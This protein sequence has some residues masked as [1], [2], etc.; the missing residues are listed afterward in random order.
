MPRMT[1]PG[2]HLSPTGQRWLRKLTWLIGPLGLCLL[3][4]AG[5][6]IDIATW[7][8]ALLALTAAIVLTIG[9]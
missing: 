2:L 6:R 3:C 8:V 1:D 7:G 5:D 9:D 4:G